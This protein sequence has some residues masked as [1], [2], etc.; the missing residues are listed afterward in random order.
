MRL[1]DCHSHWST[2]KG[3]VF[4]TEAE[5][6]NQER[7]WGTEATFQTEDEMVATF[8]KNNVR[9]MLDLATTV[10]YPME[11]DQIRATHDYTFDVQRKNKDVIFGH[12]VA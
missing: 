11:M 9:V 5:L 4:Q 8:R 6:L 7:I 3:Y 10:L 2:R 12:W 1:F